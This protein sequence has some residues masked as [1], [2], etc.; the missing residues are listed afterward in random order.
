MG[1]RGRPSSRIRKGH[2]DYVWS[3][4]FFADGKTLISA[5]EDKTL[6]FWNVA[7][8]QQ[9]RQ[10]THTKSIGGGL[11]VSPDGKTLARI[12]YIKVT[13]GRGASWYPDN[14]VR[15]DTESGKELRQLT[16]P[17]K[18]IN[19]TIRA[20]FFG[21]LFAPNGKTLITEGMDGVLRFWDATTWKEVKQISGFAGS[22]K[23]IAFAPNGKTLAVIDGNRTIRLIRIADGKD[24]VVCRGHRQ[25][26]TPS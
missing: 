11:A 17:S 20:G 1:S 23:P 22:P 3:I 10:I 26:V 19:R 9:L 6:R 25:S 4:A 5:S 21:V 7:T 18:Q 15:W 16:M 14:L 13:F 24:S 12:D 2:T 8:G